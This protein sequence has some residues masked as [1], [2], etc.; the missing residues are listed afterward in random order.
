MRQVDYG[1]E[2]ICGESLVT[3]TKL[4]KKNIILREDKQ[5][6]EDEL[7]RVNR[8]KPEDYEKVTLIRIPHGQKTELWTM[9]YS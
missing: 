1:R 3:V 5:L 4:S 6:K 9:F 2:H 7:M 8:L